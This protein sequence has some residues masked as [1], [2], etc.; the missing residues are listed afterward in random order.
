MNKRILQIILLVIAIFLV[1]D[2]FFTLDEREQA[3]ITQFGHPV[4]GAI[5][6]AGLHVKIPFIQKVHFFEKRILE[7]DGDPNRV[8][9]ADK[10]YIW[11]DI[12]ARWRIS[13]PLT[14]FQSVNTE[15]VAHSRLD[16]IIDGKTRDIV[17]QNTL[18]EIVRASDRQMEFAVDD[19]PTFEEMMKEQ[20]QRDGKTASEVEDQSF[21]TSKGKRQLI[22][23][24]ILK[25]AVKDAELLG[26]ELV[27]VRIKR[28]NYEEQVRQKVYDR[29]ISERQKISA[30]YRSTGEGEKARILGEMKKELD[31]IES[32]AYRSAQEI[33]GRA[34]AEATRLYAEAYEKNPDFFE[35]IKTLESYKETM[36]KKGTL[37]LSTD[38][39]YLQ[40]LKEGK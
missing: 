32:E 24:E 23:E 16:G 3:I 8:P 9:T 10:K 35:F 2:A 37:I 17:A 20:D 12:F 15:N 33:Q 21:N 36:N 40:E 14:F 5:V 29:M 30:W 13:D 7:W 4:G 1:A 22:A 18:I 31:R 27:D 26:I 19:V 11:I 39:D 34:D 28:V 6:N 25:K 38:S